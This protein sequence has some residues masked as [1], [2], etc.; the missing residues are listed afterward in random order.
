MK[1]TTEERKRNENRN[2]LRKEKTDQQK[3]KG[4][5]EGGRK[6]NLVTEKTTLAQEKKIET[7]KR[8]RNRIGKIAEYGKHKRN[9][10]YGK[11]K[12][13]AEYELKI[14]ENTEKIKKQKTENEH[15]RKKERSRD[16]GSHQD[17]PSV[18]VPGRSRE[19]R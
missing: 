12:R 15:I 4:G 1:E 10:E 19:E 8:K 13:N 17:H 3:R 2:R 11:Y 6:T 7:C 9:A 16:D 14:R 18:R 5:K